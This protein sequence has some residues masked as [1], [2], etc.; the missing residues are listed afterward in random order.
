ICTLAFA[1]IGVF[2]PIARA[3]APTSVGIDSVSTDTVNVSWTLDSP[4]TQTP[5]MV[6]SALSDFS[7]YI[8]S[9]TGSLGVETTS[10]HNLYSNTTY[11][12][13]VKVSAEPDSNYCAA[14][15]TITDPNPIEGEHFQHVYTSSITVAW[16]ASNNSTGTYFQIELG[17]T[18]AIAVPL[19]DSTTVL[20]S[21]NFSSLIPNTTYFVHGQTLGFSGIASPY[22]KF[23]STIT[24]AVEPSAFTFSAVSSTQII[25][26]WNPNGN[27]GGTLYDVLISTDNF[28]TTKTSSSTIE[29]FYATESLIPNTTYSFKVAA[30][31][32]NSIKTAYT[33][34]ISS[35]SYAAVPAES[36]STFSSIQEDS[37]QVVWLANDNPSYTEYYLYISTAGDFSGIDAGPKLWF[38]NPN[39]AVNPLDPSTT[40]YFRVKARDTL[41]RETAYLYLGEE[42]TLAGADHNPPIIIDLQDGD[43]TWRGAVS[44]AYQVYFN[45]LGSRVSKFQVKITTGQ[46]FT[47]ELIA[48]WADVVTNI[49][50]QE[51]NTAWQLPTTVF[52]SIAENTTSWV[53][54]RVYDMES[55]VAISTDVFYVIRDLTNPVITDNADSPI[56]WSHTD[57]GVF[58]VN[59]ADTLSSLSNVQ[60][61]ASNQLGMANAN[62][63]AWTDIDAITSSASYTADWGV[64][65]DALQDS[66]TNYISVKA[67]DMAG[68]TVIEADVFKILKNTEGPFVNITGPLSVYVST[69]TAVT[70]TSVKSIVTADVVLNEIAFIDNASSKYFDGSGF[71]SAG[72]V[73]FNPTG[74]ESWSYDA[75]TMSLSNL[76]VYKIVARSKDTNANYSSPYSTF[77]FTIDIDSPSVY[78]S[79]PI[80]GTTV[81]FMDEITGTASDV[82]A[83]LSSVNIGIKRSI[84]SKWWDFNGSWNS[85]QVSSS[86][87]GIGSWAFIADEALRGNL[88]N[89]KEHSIHVQSQ[90]NASPSNVSSVSITTFTIHDGVAPGE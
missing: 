64:N 66:A 60:Y 9:T 36:G 45:D 35:L 55:N 8:S 6:I 56:G 46:N 67:I 75:S 4:A 47:G 11:Y 21:H 27:P 18:E 24:L 88:L 72:A 86:I 22:T 44:G 37:I 89:G 30:I 61:S 81:Y 7:S 87:T 3:A 77:T 26:S 19:Q 74:L 14:I 25:T 71:S 50:A 83:G 58:D 20:L 31:N 39:Y 84:D 40:Y 15:T 51:Y 34:I 82:G 48:D 17:I 38:T 1:F 78:I 70:G 68:N 76:A 10:Y 63:I 53:S 69:L 12:F 62:V 52:N 2:S 41:D 43:E 73:W 33:S 85:V 23:G 57:P 79:S 90:D 32:G 65:F 42:K 80:A 59:F 5:F 13:K 49:D 16:S 54:V 28:L 29:N